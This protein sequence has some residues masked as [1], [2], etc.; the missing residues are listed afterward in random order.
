[1]TR[2]RRRLILSHAMKRSLDGRQLHLAPSPFLK[3]LPPH[4]TRPIER[5]CWR[6]KRPAH[7]QLAL[8]E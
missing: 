5:S 3:F 4:L 1:M 7:E 6:P 8:F 2:A